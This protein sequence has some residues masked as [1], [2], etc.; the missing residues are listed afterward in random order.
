MA[1]LTTNGASVSE[2]IGQSQPIAAAAPSFA[3]NGFAA[4]LPK[5]GG[6]I[7]G[8]DEKVDVDAYRG[9]ARLSVPLPIRPVRGGVTPELSLTYGSGAGNGPFGAGWNVGVPAIVRRTDKG[10]P[11][12]QDEEES[13]SFLVHGAD[14]VVRA[15]EPDGTPAVRIHSLSGDLLSERPTTEYYEVRPYRPRV[16][17][18]FSRIEWWRRIAT[19]SEGARPCRESFWRVISRT[20]VI[21]LYGFSISARLHAPED[22]AGSSRIFQ[23]YLERIFDDRGN[24][25]QCE[26]TADDGEEGGVRFASPRYLAAVK[27]G[28]RS[29]YVRREWLAPAFLGEDGGPLTWQFEL[30]FDYGPPIGGPLE[31]ISD[32]LA[33][34]ES[35]STKDRR[36]APSSGPIRGDVFTSYRS[37]FV[38]RTRRLCRRI[39]SYHRISGA[40]EGLVRSL[41]L[42][43]DENP[44]LS[45]LVAITQVAWNGTAGS[46]FPP[47]Q[48]AYAAVP[49]LATA[50][51]QRLTPDA[52]PTLRATLDRPHYAW[53]DLDAEGAPGALFQ[54]AGGAWLF[55]RNKGG[56]RFTPPQPVDYQPALAGVAGGTTTTA[57]V[58]LLDLGGDGQL[59][60]VD[61]SRPAAGFRE[62]ASDYSWDRF[63]PFAHSPT[64]DPGDPNVRFVDLDGDGLSDL[65]R[66]E[67]GAYVW[68]RS[69]GEDGFA[70]PE[71]LA[72]ES[73]ERRGPR[74]LFADRNDVV[75]LADISGDG[76]TDLVRI[77]NGEVCYWPN[78]GHGRFG[79]RT[80]LTIREEDGTDSGEQIVFDRSE[81]FTS[82]RIRLLDIDGTGST[83]LAYIGANGLRCWRNQ[84][85]NG[86]SRPVTVPFPPVDNPD[87]VS[88][89]DLFANG[90]S[91]LVFAPGTPGLSASLVYL[92][93]VGG[94]SLEPFVSHELHL[95]QKP[96]LLV[97][98][99]NN[100]GGET[101]FFYTSS[102]QFCVEDRDNGR[103]WITKTGFP[104][105]V[106]ARVEQRDLVTGKIL[107]NSYRYRHG[108]YDGREREFCGFAYVEQQDSVRHEDFAR[109]ATTA[110]AEGATNAEAMFHLPSSIT[111]TW[112]HTGAVLRG[113]ALERRLRSEYFTADPDAL[114]LSETTL[115]DV[116]SKEAAEAVRALKGS[117]LRQE[118]Y[119]GDSPPTSVSLAAR[120]YFVSEQSY[121][122]RLLQ[123]AGTNRHS[124]FHIHAVQQI[125][126]HYER[127]ADDPRVE[128]RFTL[129]VDDWGNVI[130][131]AHAA[132]GRRAC[133]VM[134]DV[135]FLTEEERAIQSRTSLEY[136]LRRYTPAVSDPVWNPLDHHAPMLCEGIT[137]EI[138][139]VR[140]SGPTGFFQ[141][142][143]VSSLDRAAHLSELPY[144]SENSSGGS[145]ARRRIEH[146]RQHYWDKEQAKAL[147]LGRF[148]I[149]ALPHQS[150]R[151]AFTPTLVQRLAE[152]AG[153]SISPAAMLSAGYRRCR[154]LPAAHFPS[155]GIWP[156]DGDVD[157]WWAPSPFQ[158]HDAA[159]FFVPLRY[160]DS[161]YAQATQRFGVGALMPEHITDPVGNETRIQNDYR[162]LQPRQITDTNGS[163][164][165]LR[166]DLRG[167][168]AAMALRGNDAH[169]TGDSLNGINA[170]LTD[171]DIG[172]FFTDPVPLAHPGSGSSLSIRRATARFVYDIFAACD[173][174]LPI[175]SPPEPAHRTS[176]RVAP[177]WAATVARQFHTDQDADSAVEIAFAYSNGFGEIAQIKQLTAPGP[178]DPL[179]ISSSE[180]DPRWIG[181]GWKIHDNKN[182]VVRE[183]EPFFA[184]S[185]AFEPGRMEGATHTTFYDPLQRMQ[186]RLTPH[187]VLLRSGAVAAMSPA[188]H[189]YEKH[190]RGAWG[191]IVWDG[192]D[193]LLLHPLDD[194]DVGTLLRKLPPADVVP[195]WY[196]QRVDPALSRASWPGD[197]RRQQREREA[198]VR[199]ELHAATPTRTFID[200][201][202]RVFLS[203]AHHRRDQNA[204]DEFLHTRTDYDIEG[205]QRAVI[206]AKRRAVMQWDYS[207]VGLPWRSR[208]MDS[209]RRLMLM[210]VDGKP[211]IEWDYQQRRIVHEFDLLRRPKIVR[212][213]EE[214][215]EETREAYTYGEGIANDAANYLRGRL[216]R[217]QDDGG[218]L[219]IARYD[220]HGQPIRTQRTNRLEGDVA[221][222][223]EDTFDAQSRL[224]R[225]IS[226][227]SIIA[228]KYSPSGHLVHVETTPGGTIVADIVY[229]ASGQRLFLRHGGDGP[230]MRSVFDPLTGRLHLQIAPGHQDLH[231]VFDPAGNITHVFDGAIEVE[232]FA[233]QR[234]EPLQQFT[235]DSL[236]RLITAR[237]REH[238]SRTSGT[239]NDRFAARSPF[240]L[241]AHPAD[242][243]AFRNYTEHYEYDSVGNL[244]YQRHVAG[245]GSWTRTFDVDVASNRLNIVSI[246]GTTVEQLEHDHHGNVVRLAHLSEL[247]WD[248]RDRL[249]ATVR[250]GARSRFAYDIDGQRVAKSEP[251]GTRGYLGEFEF[252]S[253]GTARHSIII[254]DGAG[255]LAIVDHS[256]G[257]N[258][259]VRL[260]LPNHLGSSGVEVD[261]S[262][263]DVLAREEFYPYG[264]SSYQAP[265][266][267]GPARRYRFTAKERDESTGLNY[268]G[269]R[270]YAPWLA[271]WV[272][273]DP[274]GVADSTNRFSYTLDNPIRFVDHSGNSSSDF[275]V[276]DR[277]LGAAKAIAGVAETA[278]GVVIAAAGGASSALG[279]GIPLFAAG[280]LVTAHGLDT[281][282]AGLGQLWSGQQTDTLTSQALQRAGVSGPTANII[283]ATVGVVGTL[284]ATALGRAPSLLGAL[285]G[286]TAPPLVHLTTAGRAASIE[287]TQTLGLGRS[288]IYAGPASLAERS[289]LGITLRTGLLPS[290]ATT[291]VPIS[292]AALGAFRVPA[293]VG[294]AT[295]WQRFSGTVYSAG[296]GSVNLATGAFTRTGLPIKQLQWYGLDALMNFTARTAQDFGRIVGDVLSPPLE[297]APSTS[298]QKPG[299][300]RK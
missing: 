220:W 51:V 154:D 107:V 259:L 264:D 222:S 70:L 177:V 263:G 26:Y 85:G 75:Y 240:D 62:R 185:H 111:R 129:E 172:K 295:L 241:C 25:A 119:S 233:G 20:N 135:G 45:K 261:K 270:Y 77:R 234:I 275:R 134:R 148:A 92:H 286:S 13:D 10:V 174:A 145:P 136:S 56:G 228:R 223:R 191:D 232:F 187:L 53:L 196:Q 93:L 32:V 60:A 278:A 89:V 72:W 97:R 50:R 273:P 30:A 250:G 207:M 161:F 265:T 121:R 4:N 249:V 239:W 201:R 160:F 80:P 203:V 254:R 243:H 215:T 178:L 229:R 158:Q 149:P 79:P 248:Y 236:Y 27:Y 106:V 190:V 86:F 42:T 139:G 105:Q 54:S 221:R 39:L 35:P 195:T 17:N 267:G 23:W 59:D 204:P 91:C 235:Y 132:Y 43:Y 199:T 22:E 131:S 299:P 164:T 130:Q 150:F 266:S 7:R 125:D 64:L 287:A 186:A 269:A 251:G 126:Y 226:G 96:H 193:S 202:G 156:A 271:R 100:L 245:A 162:L 9:T 213:R 87:A 282:S 66:S 230:G 163:L 127:Q 76:L 102:A 171:A 41:E 188:G 36:V 276:L 180:S 14:E 175:G 242:T 37:G 216:Y 296:A 262:S 294:P 1:S 197:E 104:V 109:H 48:L 141:P 15:L 272:S 210:A 3:A 117:I 274:T 16:E 68:Q 69:L 212:V 258:A 120:P 281:T 128:H 253:T 18:A 112:F 122:V 19:V 289:G 5:G 257:T 170:N 123:A 260:Q 65:V 224:V 208:S 12:Y 74:L 49:D 6:A 293:V 67:H 219:T 153:E 252:Y 144:Q 209:G 247:A 108:H 84:S 151:L 184:A 181:S 94:Q 291:P 297:Y 290:Q 268:H 110:L 189:S 206:D 31:R 63:T 194:P 113:E 61:F 90:T 205:N 298:T 244:V 38:I 57:A 81:L 46:A 55:A 152:E 146:M 285:R 300:L 237:G 246:G 58:T 192:N 214:A 78:L 98:H 95:S 137:W 279:V 168:V 176:H 83:D 142:S 28:N 280:V 133:G 88:V 217:Q 183:Y 40:Y 218:T 21:S 166:F 231:H 179:A 24:A 200:P 138:T 211:A 99:T 8:I 73:D 29:P 34:C 255:I 11:R 115:P 288:T 52:L 140:P 44:Y 118:I 284:G 277:A 47:L 157:A 147:P 2:K 143:D 116:S 198:A 227:A 283:D 256:G 82:N 101:H 155:S 292:E 159:A 167:L 238:C 165:E 169:P 173:R 225:S 124:A 114:L 103:P 71:R 182:S 33:R